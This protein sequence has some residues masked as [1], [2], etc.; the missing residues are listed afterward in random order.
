MLKVVFC[1]IYYISLCVKA[2]IIFFLTFLYR[3]KLYKIGEREG[4]KFKG[5]RDLPTLQKFI[6]DETGNIREVSI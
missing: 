5:S 6:T 1:I 4:K 2:D 3:L